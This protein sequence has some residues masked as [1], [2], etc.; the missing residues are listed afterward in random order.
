MWW[1]FTSPEN[2]DWIGPILPAVDEPS[3]SFI[4]GTNN[5]FPT[6]VGLLETRNQILVRF[7]KR[8]GGGPLSTFQLKIK[9][10]T[11]KKLWVGFSLWLFLLH[12]KI[13]SLT[14]V[15]AVVI[16]AVDVKRASL[17]SLKLVRAKIV[18]ENLVWQMNQLLIDA[19]DE[20]ASYIVSCL[21]W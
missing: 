14:R 15:D 6:G 11:I 12:F 9:F 10:W 16:N 17:T 21:F 8:R 20:L 3:L 4:C 2:F 18:R 1:F 19:W 7:F 13:T 5:R